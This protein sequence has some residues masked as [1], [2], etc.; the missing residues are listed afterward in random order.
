MNLILSRPLRLLHLMNS[1]SLATFC[2]HL[3][4]HSDHATSQFLSLVLSFN[5][6]QHVYF[7]SSQPESHNLPIQQILPTL[8]F[9]S[10][11]WTASMIMGL[12]L[13]YH[14]Q[15][16]NIARYVHCIIKDVPQSVS[17]VVSLLT[18]NMTCICG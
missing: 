17:F 9:F 2:L 14:A 4:N 1:S 18:N 7:P 5:L 8:L 15:H 10:T 6:T 16:V 12:D 3:D 11:H 13:T